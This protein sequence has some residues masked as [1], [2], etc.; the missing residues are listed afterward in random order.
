[1]KTRNFTLIGTILMMVA[2]MT[3]AGQPERGERNGNP[4]N[5]NRKASRSTS[6]NEVTSEMATPLPQAGRNEIR[7]NADDRRTWS[8]SGHSRNDR[9]VINNNRDSKEN[10]NF[11]DPAK[12]EDKKEFKGNHNSINENHNTLNGNRN[13]HGNSGYA[14]NRSYAERSSADHREFNRH[15]WDNHNYNR[16]DWEHRNYRWN[17]HKWSFS[18]YYRKGHVP[19]YFRENRNYWYYP[20]YGH[21]LRGFRHEPFLFYSGQIPFFFEDGF[22]FRYYTGIGYVWIE[23]PYDIWFNDLPYQAVRVRIS[24]RMYFKLGNAFFERGTWGFR[25]ALLPDRFYDP[26]YD[27]GFEGELS[28][29]F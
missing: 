28:G 9:E 8:E 1:M 19:Y 23:D 14:E 29:R 26:V 21:I 12:L 7:N 4:E 20:E 25:L 11:N 3:A 15:L 13:E 16:Q 22:F 2:V 24:G 18:N 6:G 17:D 10:R 5:N 27:R